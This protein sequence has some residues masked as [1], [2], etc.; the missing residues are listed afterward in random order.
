[1]PS[2]AKMDGVVFAP[3]LTKSDVLVL[4]NLAADIRAASTVKQVKGQRRQNTESPVD[5]G[6]TQ[7]ATEEV[8]LQV[9]LTHQRY[10]QKG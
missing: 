3:D 10:S 9:G 1:M 4:R 7:V 6:L 2:I 5:N 8:A